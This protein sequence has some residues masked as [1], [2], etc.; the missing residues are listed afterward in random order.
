M[1][2]FVSSQAIDSEPARTLIA[3]LRALG[4]AVE[5]SPSHPAHRND[6]RWS[7]WYGSGLPRALARCSVFV[8][9]VDVGWDASTWMGE[10]AH[11]AQALRSF[12]WNPEGRVVTAPGML[13][14]LREPLPSDLSAALARLREEDGAG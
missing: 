9:V 5:H 14:Y 10:E 13:P 12:F 8:A 4:V 2:V 11:A 6:R 1:A 3:G 7:D